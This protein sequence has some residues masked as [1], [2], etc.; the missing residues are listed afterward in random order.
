MS[1]KQNAIYISASSSDDEC[2][3]I[4]SSPK[5]TLPA[6]LEIKISE[7][8]CFLSDSSS[9]EEFDD[10]V[11]AAIEAEEKKAKKQE[12]Q[13]AEK[14]FKGHLNG[15]PVGPL[16]IQEF[17]KKNRFYNGYYGTRHGIYQYRP[18]WSKKHSEEEHQA[19]QKKFEAEQA[20][21]REQCRAETREKLIKEYEDKMRVYN[22]VMKQIAEGTYETKRKP[23]E[24]L[25]PRENPFYRYLFN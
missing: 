5:P 21:A 11:I 25:D 24:P 3:E 23:L 12:K 10:D 7:P 18:N 19:W 6:N 17:R 13:A 22:A 14:F 2:V 15:V 8:E 16:Q 20:A 1:T 4:V 9:D